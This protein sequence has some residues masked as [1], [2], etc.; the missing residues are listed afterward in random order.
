ME[1]IDSV[2]EKVQAIL[3]AYVKER[4]N[5]IKSRKKD[6]KAA[7]HAL[8]TYT[9]RYAPSSTSIPPQRTQALLLNLLI[10]E[11]MILPADKKLGSNMSGAFLI[12]DPVLRAFAE[13]KILPVTTLLTHLSAAMNGPRNPMVGIESDPI[14]EGLYEWVVHILRSEAYQKPTGLV[15]DT[16]AKCFSDP[17]HWNIRVA[18]AVVRDEE[19]EVKNRAEWRDVLAAAR[20]EAVEGDADGDVEMEKEMEVEKIETAK[21]VEA[22]EKVQGPM[23]AVGMWK[24]R[25]IGWMM[26]GDDDE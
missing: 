6:D 23:K 25:P 7:H 15:E 2:R 14:K 21:P 18:E 17:T 20:S 8:S 5:E 10:T 11:K 19:V 22:K 3:K 26:E 12:W 4:K 13:S 24:R 9:L 16:L 1:G